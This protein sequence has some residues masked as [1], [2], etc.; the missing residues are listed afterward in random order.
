[1]ENGRAGGGGKG[2]GGGREGKLLF[3]FNVPKFAVN[4]FLDFS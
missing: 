2:G 4:I 1:M 3:S